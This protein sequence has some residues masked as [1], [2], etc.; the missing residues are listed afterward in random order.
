MINE[1]TPKEASAVT[2]FKLG[3]KVYVEIG[4]E[5]FTGKIIDEDYSQGTWAYKVQF[6]GQHGNEGDWYNIS[7]LNLFRPRQEVRNV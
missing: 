4:E 2:K 5:T 1:A 6:G 7:D 3:D